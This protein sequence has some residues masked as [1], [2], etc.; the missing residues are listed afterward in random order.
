MFGGEINFRTKKIV[1]DVIE[2][3][4]PF[5]GIL[6]HP[7]LAKFTAVSHYAHNNLKMPGPMGVISIPSDKRDAVIGIDNM[8]RDAVA[9]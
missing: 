7:A 6:G 8:Y 3:P 5:K 9:A 4:L 1:F 2:L